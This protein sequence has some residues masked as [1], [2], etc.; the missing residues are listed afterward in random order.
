MD[1]KNRDLYGEGYLDRVFQVFNGLRSQ[2][3]DLTLAKTPNTDQCIETVIKA[4][5]RKEKYFAGKGPI[6]KDLDM[7]LFL[8]RILEENAPL[9]EYEEYLF[10]YLGIKRDRAELSLSQQ[11]KIVVQ[12]VAQVLWHLEKNNIPSIEKMA[13][14]ILDK[15]NPFNILFDLDTFNSRTISN[16]VSEIF[17]ISKNSRRGRP[18][19]EEI[20]SSFFEELILIPGIFLD[21]ETVNFPKL[22]FTIVC[23]TRVLQAHGWRLGEIQE[24]KFIDLYVNPLRHKFFP[25]IKFLLNDWTKEAF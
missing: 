22:R 1:R 20:P 5:R 2:L 12:S 16:W 14:K 25:I 15:K 24:S 13:K 7:Y 10:G 9:F 21:D 3:H 17:P 23:L 6:S 18:A 11:N 4:L 19:K 8:K